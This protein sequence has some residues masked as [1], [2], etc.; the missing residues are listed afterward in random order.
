M[1]L[2]NDNS[3]IFEFNQ[4]FEAIQ[5]APGSQKD[6]TACGAKSR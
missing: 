6:A 2:I 5:L 1:N 3:K 4:L